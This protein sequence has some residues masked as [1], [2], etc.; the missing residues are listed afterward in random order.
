MHMVV[1]RAAGACSIKSWHISYAA[2]F[3]DDA[4][5]HR[6]RHQAVLQGRALSRSLLAHQAHLIASDVSERLHSR[7]GHDSAPLLPL[8]L[9]EAVERAGPDEGEGSVLALALPVE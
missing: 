5:T 7:S 3:G 4:D 6:P 1:S 9:A 8:V 2:A